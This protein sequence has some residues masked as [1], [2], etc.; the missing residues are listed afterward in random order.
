MVYTHWHYEGA[1]WSR[2]WHEVNST[3]SCQYHSGG[4]GGIRAAW[5]GHPVELRMERG[6]FPM[7][8]G[9]QGATKRF[10]ESLFLFF[11]ELLL[12]H[13]VSEVMVSFLCLDFWDCHV[14][15]PFMKPRDSIDEPMKHKM[16]FN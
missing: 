14:W 6:I 11:S 1:S 4:H 2:S 16:M 8:I 15:Q 3:D 13:V 10:R 12:F 9:S 7:K 5:R